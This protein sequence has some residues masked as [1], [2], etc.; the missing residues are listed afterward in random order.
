[1][2]SRPEAVLRMQL[3]YVPSDLLAPEVKELFVRPWSFSGNA[4]YP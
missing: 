4:D 1:M 3:R 2:K